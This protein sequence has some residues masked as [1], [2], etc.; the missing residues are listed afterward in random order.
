MTEPTTAKRVSIA[1][2]LFVLAACSNA[3]APQRVVHDDV[4]TVTR[5][6]SGLRIS[7]TTSDRIYYYV[8][9]YVLGVA[10]LLP[11]CDDPVACASIP[12]N[13]SITVPQA[14]ITGDTDGSRTDV[15]YHWK[16]QTSPAGNSMIDFTSLSV[17]R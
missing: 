14:S 17:P 4:V 8:Y 11:K 13:G 7:N 16:I 9:A 3:T 10:A 6:A 5:D 2:M 12:P 15:V 1:A